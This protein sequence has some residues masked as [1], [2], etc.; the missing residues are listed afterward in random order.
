MKE[1]AL[2]FCLQGYFFKENLLRRSRLLILLL[3]KL[4][5]HAIIFTQQ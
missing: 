5:V 4:L 2:L 1:R 3:I